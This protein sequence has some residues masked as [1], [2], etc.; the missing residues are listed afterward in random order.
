MHIDRR[1]IITFLYNTPTS[2][3]HTHTRTRVHTH[4]NFTQTR[5]IAVHTVKGRRRLVHG[6]VLLSPRPRR[7]ARL[8]P[9]SNSVFFAVSKEPSSAPCEE[10]A[11]QFVLVRWKWRIASSSGAWHFF[12]FWKLSCLFNNERGFGMKVVTFENPNESVLNRNLRHVSLNT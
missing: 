10:R 1:R 2:T 8:F 5:L 4:E 7:R 11:G 3:K 12:E 6:R 9:N